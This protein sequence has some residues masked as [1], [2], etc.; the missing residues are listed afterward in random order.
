MSTS[1]SAVSRARALIGLERRAYTLL[2]GTSSAR[3]TAEIDDL[4]SSAKRVTSAVMT[5]P[6]WRKKPWPVSRSRVLAAA[7]EPLAEAPRVRRAPP[8]SERRSHHRPH[9]PPPGVPSSEPRSQSAQVPVRHRSGFYQAADRVE[10]P[11][12]CTR[13]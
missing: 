6:P 9:P 13:P 10:R 3:Q 8:S 11:P 5:S 2:R 7:C 12:T 4:D 1:S